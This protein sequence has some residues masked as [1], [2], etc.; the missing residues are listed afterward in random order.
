[1]LASG[2][3][4]HIIP[5]IV[6]IIGIFALFLICL[7]MNTLIGG[8]KFVIVYVIKSLFGCLGLILFVILFLYAIAGLLS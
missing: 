8:L 1:M 4:K 6:A 7:F 3:L 5:K 2:T